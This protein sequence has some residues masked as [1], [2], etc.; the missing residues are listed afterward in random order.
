MG[1]GKKKIIQQEDAQESALDIDMFTEI[2]DSDSQ[3]RGKRTKGKGKKLK[4]SE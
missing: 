2:E 4:I 3:A 1:K